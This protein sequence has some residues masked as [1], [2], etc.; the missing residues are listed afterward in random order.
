MIS[1]ILAGLIHELAHY[2]AA[3]YYGHNLVFRRQGIRFIWDMPN[4]TP[5]HQ[6]LMALSGFGLEVLFI[7]ILFFAGL[8]LY[9]YVV[10]LHLIAY[11]FYAG[12]AND[13]KWI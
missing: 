12:E 6:R 13:F 4:D 9:P 7:P 1:L 3:L 11:P 8:T 5:K 10:I 2:L